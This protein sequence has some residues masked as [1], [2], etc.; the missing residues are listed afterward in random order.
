M[1]NDEMITVPEAIE[2]L[3]KRSANEVA[4]ILRA[5]G[6]TGE[7]RDAH[8]CPIANYVKRTTGD[9]TVSVCGDVAF[10]GRIGARH[11]VKMPRSAWRFVDRF[12]NL[13][14]DYKDLRA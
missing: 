10:Y 8:A 11:E 6:V 3:R 7:P 5:A 14:P 9:D 12:D 2:R 13:H 1:V 4:D